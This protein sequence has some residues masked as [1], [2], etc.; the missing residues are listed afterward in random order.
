[1]LKVLPQILENNFD[2]RSGVYYTE[3]KKNFFIIQTFNKN[4][5]ASIQWDT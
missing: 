4:H 3:P 5:S 1:M 2:V